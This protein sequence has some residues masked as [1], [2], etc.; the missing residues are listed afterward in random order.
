[1]ENL[2]GGKAGQENE[3]IIALI[4]SMNSQFNQ[5]GHHTTLI[6][7][8]LL[9]QL[10]NYGGK[11]VWLTNLLFSALNYTIQVLQGSTDPHRQY[12]ASLKVAYFRQN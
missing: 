2:L 5:V 11:S 9:V 10:H 7:A 1:M 6:K 3:L 12:A 4:D 8:H